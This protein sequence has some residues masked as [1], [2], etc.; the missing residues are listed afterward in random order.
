VNIPSCISVQDEVHKECRFIE[1]HF[2]SPF[3]K[4]LPGI[5]PP[6]TETAWLVGFHGIKFENRSLSCLMVSSSLLFI[7]SHIRFMPFLLVIVLL[8]FMHLY[9][10]YCLN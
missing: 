9:N 5:M 2:V 6:E 10:V 4:H 1:G 7:L 3:S 8:I